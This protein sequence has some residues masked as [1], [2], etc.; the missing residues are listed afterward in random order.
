MLLRY[1]QEYS[2]E[3]PWSQT[4]SSVLDYVM[5]IAIGNDEDKLGFTVTPRSSRRL[6]AKI[7]TDLDF[8]D[9]ICLDVL[10]DTLYQA[11]NFLSRVERATDIVW[12]QKKYFEKQIQGL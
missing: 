11:K 7:V 4:Y 2:K 9:D 3:T 10:S 12:L 6:P 1:L 8:A 5:R